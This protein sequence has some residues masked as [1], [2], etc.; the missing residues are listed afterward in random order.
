MTPSKTKL[1]HYRTSRLLDSACRQALYMTGGTV[2]PMTANDRISSRRTTATVASRNRFR[3][4]SASLR[5]G[6]R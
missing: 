1:H 2:I 3:N 4:S 6:C 5:I